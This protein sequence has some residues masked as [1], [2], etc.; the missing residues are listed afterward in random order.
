M[1]MAKP[2][3][4]SFEDLDIFKRAR[5]IAKEIYKIT[6]KQHFSR[7]YALCNQIRRAS[8]SIMSNI[9]EG[10]ERGTNPEFIKFLNIAKGSCAEV[11][12]QLLIA[13]DQNYINK[14]TC[15]KLTEECRIINGMIYNLISYLKESK[16]PGK[17]FKRP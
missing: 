3:V 13:L 17:K 9:A 5:E 1:M 7:D 10:F 2:A 6:T 4:K 11:R 15:E 8:I 12:A 14:D 16:Y